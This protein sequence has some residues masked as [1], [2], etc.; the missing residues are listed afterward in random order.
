MTLLLTFV[1]KQSKVIPDFLFKIALS[2]ASLYG[3]HS[4]YDNLKSTHSNPTPYAFSGQIKQR[5]FL[6]PRLRIFRSTNSK[7]TLPQALTIRPC[8][9]ELHVITA[10]RRST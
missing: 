10:P 5:A 3:T 2:S 8:A 1:E 6:F 9:N 4:T 7:A